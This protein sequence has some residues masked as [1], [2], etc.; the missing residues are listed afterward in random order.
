MLCPTVSSVLPRFTVPGH[1]RSVA[2]F[3]AVV[4]GAAGLLTGCATGDVAMLAEISGGQKVRVPF[5]KGGPEM[6]SE[7]GV[8]INQATFTLNADKK[9][10]YVFSYTDSRN[11]ALRRVLVEDV[12][13][14][15]PLTLVDDA[16]PQPAAGGKWLGETSPVEWNDP[17]ITWLATISNSLRIY[18]FT[19]TFADGRTLVVHQGSFFPA[20]MKA[21][22]RQTMG[23]NY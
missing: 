11:R 20:P 17:R 4:L 21:A 14:A 10:F 6:T 12:S 8:L 1:R 16:K 9:I 15:A 23:Q 2:V 19:L 5:G 22:V 7:D 18:R 3:A 13:D